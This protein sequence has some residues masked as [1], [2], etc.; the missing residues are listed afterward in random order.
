MI[1]DSITTE[2]GG[3]FALTDAELVLDAGNIGASFDFGRLRVTI[4][5]GASVRWPA[6]Q[7]NPYT[8]DGRSELHAA[9]L[10]VVLPFEKTNVQR[11]R[12]S[13]LP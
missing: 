11:V 8:K 9:K 2:K 10:V 5:E 12:L 1:A 6:R 3:T 13:V 4:P 7:H